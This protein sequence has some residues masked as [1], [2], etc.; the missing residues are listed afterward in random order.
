LVTDLTFLVAAFNAAL[1]ATS[2]A[3]MVAFLAGGAAC[4]F[5]LSLATFFAAAS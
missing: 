1:A 3:L 2:L 4:N 5:S